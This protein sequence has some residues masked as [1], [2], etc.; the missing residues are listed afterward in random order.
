MTSAPVRVDASLIAAA[1]AGVSGR[2]PPSP[3]I[4]STMIAAVFV[5]TAAS[6]AAG[7]LAGT[8]RTPGSSGSNGAR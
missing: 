6:S 4:G 5:E 8:K 3:W 2:T 1:N 7:S